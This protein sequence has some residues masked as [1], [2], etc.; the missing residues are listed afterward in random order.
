MRAGLLA[1][2]ILLLA[3]AP[4]SA[5]PALVKLGDFSDPVHV[6]SP[7]LDSRVFVVERAGLVRIVG[8]GTF[9]DLRQETNTGNVERGLLSIAFPPDYAASGL[10]YVFLTSEPS[11]DVEVQ[12]YRRSANPDVASPTRVR[13]LLD[14][15]HTAGNHN[16]GQLQFGPDGAL[17]VSIGDN[18]DSGTAGNPNSP[19]GKI[20]R[21]VPATGARQ[22]WASGLRNPW[23]F[24]FDRDT[25]DL[26][27]GDV[28]GSAYEEINWSRGPNAGQGVNYGWP[29]NEGPNGAD[30]CGARA[31]LWH[32]NGAFC[33]IV[34]GYVVRDPGL[35]TLNGRYLYGDNC[36]GR[37][38]SAALGSGQGVATPIAVSGLSSFGTDTC[39]HIYVA[40]RGANAVYRL[41]DGEPSTCTAAP[42][43]VADATAPGLRVNVLKPK[44]RSLRVAVRCS[45]ACSVAVSS[46]LRR[47]Q[48]LKV[49][50]RSLAANQRA[51]VSVRMKRATARR[52]RRAVRRRGYVRIAVTVQATDAAGNRV[53]VTRRGRIRRR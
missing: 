13:T 18:A 10:F 3:A 24:T 42:A 41:Q 15:P 45:E 17:Y 25:G 11:G 30:S 50:R 21:I 28:G 23:R 26:L 51:V 19:Y 44:R 39:G 2:T 43:P 27:I 8:G 16:G 34:G 7:P 36:N 40:A 46:R 12:E 38:W 1:A 33:A 5:A 4:A 29:C 37:L 35:P 31:A 9:L 48:R 47:V 52:L 53:S 6:A 14:V 22:V 32:Q 20:H 49:R